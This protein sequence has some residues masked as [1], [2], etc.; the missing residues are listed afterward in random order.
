MNNTNPQLFPVIYSDLC[1]ASQM[2]LKRRKLDVHHQSAEV[3]ERLK[4]E[5][6]GILREQLLAVSPGFRR[7]LL[8]SQI[9]ERLKRSCATIQISTFIVSFNLQDSPQQG[10]C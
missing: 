9:A 3:A 2:G 5:P 8:L 1:Y 6:A 10:V 4:N 7:D